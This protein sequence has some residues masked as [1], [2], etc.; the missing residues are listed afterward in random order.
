MAQNVFVF[1]TLKK[2]FPLHERGLAEAAFLGPYSTRLRFPLVIAG[3]RFAPMMFN[4]PG[5]GFRVVGELYAVDKQTL[6]NLDRLESVGRPGNMRVA[7]DVEPITG[8]R[9]ICA[10]VYMKSR[11]LARPMHSGY[12]EIYED[13]R[14]LAD[15][16]REGHR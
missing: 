8:G 15:T 16:V 13:R 2:G 14:F 7:I 6:T 12:L 3:P 11:D 1:G 10:H 4:E 9:T 5:V